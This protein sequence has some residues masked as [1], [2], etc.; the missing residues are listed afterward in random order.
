MQLEAAMP[1]PPRAAMTTSPSPTTTLFTQ[2]PRIIAFISKVEERRAID[3]QPWTEYHLAPGEFDEL[4]RRLSPDEKHEFGL[5]GI[6]LR[7][8]DQT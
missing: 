7:C 6:H 3:V 8:V 4:V 2:A 5:V 1:I